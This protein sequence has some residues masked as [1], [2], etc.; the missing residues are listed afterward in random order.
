MKF[1]ELNYL[2][3][4]F[5][6]A[7]GQARILSLQGMEVIKPW[8]PGNGLYYPSY[9]RQW[10]EWMVSNNP[11]SNNYGPVYF[12]HC[13]STCNQENGNY[14]MQPVVRIGR[15]SIT[16]SAGNYVFLPII[17]AAA[18][19]VDNGVPDNP[20]ALLNYVR[21]DLDAGDNPP[22]INQAT[23]IDAT[24]PKSQ[25]PREQIVKERLDRFLVITDVFSLD[26][27]PAQPGSKLLRTC[28]DV[29]INTVGERN[30]RVGGYWILMQFTE[31]HKR[32][33][34]HSSS[35][36][37]GSYESGML[38]EINVTGIN[39]EELI[40]AKKDRRV[41]TGDPIKKIVK[42]LKEDEQI[43]SEDHSIIEVLLRQ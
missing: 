31:P 13:V 43:S 22:D 15:Q 7:P 1:I 4:I 2:T 36:G 38:Y 6:N 30:C 3:E 27:P 5:I 39:K 24:D 33:F 17:T 20:A 35:R 37:R 9:C 26:V 34:I 40:R 28:F 10:L 19:T 11:E 21:M 23:I 18:E 41:R 42:K 25:G 12:L 14:G 16:I 32:Y 29:P 8:E